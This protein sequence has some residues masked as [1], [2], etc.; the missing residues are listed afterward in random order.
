MPPFDRMMIQPEMSTECD[1]LSSP[2]P[3]AKRMRVRLAPEEFDSK[4]EPV[5]THFNV[6]L[7]SPDERKSVHEHGA[8]AFESQTV[9]PGSTVGNLSGKHPI[10]SPLVVITRYSWS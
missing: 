7:H 4:S 3:S 9:A 8:N 2:N 1:K 5:F 6:E 10:A